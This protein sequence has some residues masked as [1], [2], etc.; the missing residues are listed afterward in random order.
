MGTNNFFN[1]DLELFNFFEN[2]QFI[3][4][5]GLKAKSISYLLLV[6]IP[7]AWPLF[8]TTYY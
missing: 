1:K 5:Q 2:V 3:H 6:V 8:Y 7:P 4:D